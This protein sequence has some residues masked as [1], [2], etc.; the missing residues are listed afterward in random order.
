MNLKQLDKLID[1][2]EGRAKRVDIE[3]HKRVLRMRFD[4]NGARH[5]YKEI[6]SEVG[7]TLERVRQIIEKYRSHLQYK[8]KHIPEMEGYL[9]SLNVPVRRSRSRKYPLLPMPVLL[10]LTGAMEIINWI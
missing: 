4:I 9:N 2:I 1:N 3:R 5:T 7:L 8:N 10:I 6:A